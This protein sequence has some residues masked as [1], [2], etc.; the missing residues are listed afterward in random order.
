MYKNH[1]IGVVI[2]AYNVASHVADVVKTLPQFVDRVV[3]VDDCGTD[4]T[5][6]LLGTLERVGVMVVRHAVN[7]GVGAAM[8]SGF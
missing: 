4:G 1:R 6:Q 7:Q 5:S 2:P 8:V 3:L